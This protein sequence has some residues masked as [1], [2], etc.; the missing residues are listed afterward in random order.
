MRR[1]NGFIAKSAALSTATPTTRPALSRAA[2]SPTAVPTLTTRPTAEYAQHHDVA[3]PDVSTTAFRPAWLVRSRLMQLHADGLIDPAELDA[4]LIWRRDHDMALSSGAS[5]GAYAPRVDGGCAGGAATIRLAALGRLRRTADALGPTRVLLLI[6]V[7]VE[8]APWSAL[9]SRLKCSDKTCRVRAVEAIEALHAHQS[10]RRV[11]PP[12]STI[13][14]VQPTRWR[15]PRQHP[16]FVGGFVIR[17]RALIASV[18]S[19][20]A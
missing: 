11:P 16:A 4:A 17:R 7:V 1:T 13:R 3:A 14:A 8:D 10:G 12:P 19:P 20:V 9:A 5:I 15:R 2:T 6:G 18:H